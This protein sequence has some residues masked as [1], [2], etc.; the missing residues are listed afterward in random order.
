MDNHNNKLK[1]SLS[2]PMITF[3]GLGNILGAGIYV[4]IGKVAGEAGYF[5]P[6][7]FLIASVI[8]ALSAFTYAELSARYPVSAGVAVFIYE[9]F[10]IQ[11]LSVLVGVLITLA[12]IVSA[13]A[14]AHGFA[15][16]VQVFV[17]MPSW[18]IILL[19]LSL[20][21]TLA[22]WGISESVAVASV[23]TLLEIAGLVM[24]IVVGADRLPEI[25]TIIQHQQASMGVIPWAGIFSASFLAFY[26]YIGFED[27]VNVAEEVK[28]PQRNMPRAILLC[29][30]ISS[31][32]YAAVTIVA[33][34]VIP[35]EQLSQSHAPLADV[36]VAA[37]GRTPVVISF[38]GIF[39]VINGSLI[40]IIMASRLVY[41]MARKRWLPGVLSRVHGRTQTP[42]NSTL[43]VVSLVL[44]FALVLNLVALAELTSYLV[45]V[46]FSLVNLSLIRIKDNHVHPEG[47]RVYS[48]WLPVAGFISAFSFLLIE[49]Y[50]LII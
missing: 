34:L 5:A 13:A 11:Q 36:Y 39:A 46:V 8:A 17:D 22:I 43:L 45:L 31:I 24:I 15:G 28:D 49:L 16:Y 6:L 50:A 14:L 4:L 10:N 26:A 35:P 33:I 18:L 12:G 38:I 1:R 44:F 25:T 21:G 29:V 3:Y 30:V 42:I 2:L 19:I 32:L 20:L 47:V 48:K 23:F 9:G 40:Q 7:A 27:M 37:T 41:G